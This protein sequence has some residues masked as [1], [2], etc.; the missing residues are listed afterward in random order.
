[1]QFDEWFNEIEV[2]SLRGER[3]FNDLDHHVP[4][5]QGSSK[6]MVEWLRAAYN[7]GYEQGKAE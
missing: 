3:F 2:F 1:M 7:A 6:R 5:S 4:D